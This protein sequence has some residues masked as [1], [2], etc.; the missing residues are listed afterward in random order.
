M[1]QGSNAPKNLSKKRPS[2]GVIDDAHIQNLRKMKKE[3]EFIRREKKNR[4]PIRLKK[5]KVEYAE[6]SAQRPLTKSY[7]LKNY[8][9][10]TSSRK[11]HNL[12]EIKSSSQKDY[13]ILN[14]IKR[15]FSSDFLEF[16]KFGQKFLIKP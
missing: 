5:P 2:D 1:K 13:S 7:N 6:P 3:K 12:I 9:P 4:S 11:N 14:D 10:S 8:N 15:S 16:K